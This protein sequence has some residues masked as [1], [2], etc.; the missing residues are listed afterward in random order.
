LNDS[1]W[2]RSNRIESGRI[3]FEFECECE[4]VYE[5]EFVLPRERREGH[6]HGFAR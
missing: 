4:F 5:C 3:E 1:A 2:L 6:R